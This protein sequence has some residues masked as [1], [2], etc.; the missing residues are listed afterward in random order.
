ML[1][2]RL[3]FLAV[4]L[5][6]FGCDTDPID[7]PD[8]VP[9]DPNDPVVEPD[10]EP[11]LGGGI[12]LSPILQFDGRFGLAEDITQ[13]CAVDTT[14]GFTE[15]RCKLE[16]NE[17]DLYFHGW[18]YNALVDN[19]TCT[20]LGIHNYMYQ[21]WQD[22]NGPALVQ[23][24]LDD[25]TGDCLE[26]TANSAGCQ[27]ACEFDYTNPQDPTAP[28][29]CYGQYQLEITRVDQAGN[30][31]VTTQGPFFWGGG[32]IGQC[33]DGAA[34][35]SNITQFLV[36]GIPAYIIVDIDEG[37]NTATPVTFNGPITVPTFSNVPVANYINSADGIPLGFQQFWSVPEYTIE[38]LDDAEEVLA[39]ILVQVEEWDTV[40][41]FVKE[42]EE[43]SD[44]DIGRQQEPNGPR[45][46][47]P[48]SG[49]PINDLFD[50]RDF[51]INQIDWVQNAD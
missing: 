30:E 32:P 13:P 5:F 1:R 18:G 4:P 19:G 20:Y 49:S 37:A 12:A 23:Y 26:D 31:E 27:P 17:L 10:P 48:E 46:L 34:Y 39:R 15:T 40:S 41:E 50:W 24:R 21:A 8:W 16:A 38:C 36:N 44:P 2:S 47:E 42:P 43:Q 3:A 9:V 45:P 51:D 25:E 33:Y 22:G 14:E 7:I 35:Y 28:N 11:I 29:C 6:V